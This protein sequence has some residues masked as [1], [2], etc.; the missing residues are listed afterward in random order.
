MRNDTL[1]RP[2][3]LALAAGTSLPPPLPSPMPSDVTV[4]L[5][6][7]RTQSDA[8]LRQAPA[9]LSPPE[10]R[11]AAGLLREADRRCYV[12]AH[13]ALRTLLGARLGVAPGNVRITREPCR[14]CGSCDGDHGRPVTGDGRVHFS[15]SHAGPLALLAL[16]PAPVG[17]D[18]EE[19]PQ[20]RT[21]GL[22]GGRLHPREAAELAGLTEGERPAAFARCWVRKEAYLKGIGVGLA[23]DVSLDYL[24]T[25]PTPPDG[26]PGWSLT[27]VEVPR[28]FAAAVA[29]SSPTG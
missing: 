4:W 10:E 20:P 6:D 2:L 9:V 12:T 23:R 29:V 15:L 27:D 25:G 24:G 11:R 8:A 16:G 22:V 5:V 28:G 19:L 14:S 18:V 1:H 17:V 21:V 3:P 13:V 26:P 7:A